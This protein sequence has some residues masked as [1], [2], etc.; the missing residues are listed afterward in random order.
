M[1]DSE[2]LAGGAPPPQPNTL[3]AVVTGAVGPGTP[4]YPVAD[5]SIGPARGNSATT[6]YAVGLALKAGAN[7]ERTPYR[8]A[9]PVTLTSEEWTAVLNTGTE[10]I[11][12]SPYY[13]SQSA[14]G[15]LTATKPG[16]GLIC[17]VGVASSDLCLVVNPSTHTATE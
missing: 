6:A 3:T 5:G 2:I 8:Y 13:V 11:P 15:V 1:S 4:V 16:S 9:G 7:G 10:L 12:G 17:L 14:P